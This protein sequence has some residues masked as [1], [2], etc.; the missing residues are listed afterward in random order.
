[1]QQRD[2]IQGLR[3]IAVL[4]VI[5]FHANKDWV[6]GGF[7][8]VDVFLVISGYLISS[9]VLRNKAD[10]DFRFG[11]FYLSRIRRIVPAYLVLL[12]VA[13]LCMAFLLTP[14]DYSSFAKSL[15]R[16]L[17]FRSN[18]FFS[19]RN[20]YFGPE[21]YE[22][23]LLHTWSLA[24][25]MQFYL[26]LPA[27]IIF[28]PKRFIG[29]VLGAVA[30]VLFTYASIRL[31][32]GE[33]QS[34][35]FSLAARIPEFLVGSL[36]ALYAFGKDW[37]DKKANVAAIV[38]MAMVLASFF[39]VSEENAFPGLLAVLPCAGVALM[40]AARSG[41]LN[42]LLAAKPLVVIGALSY[43]LYLW[44]WPILAAL[45]YFYDT[46]HLTPMMW[47]VFI[48][49]TL[50]S[51]YASYRFV[52]RPF[53]TAAPGR[54]RYVR[55]VALGAAM[56]GTIGVA[57][58]LNEKLVPPLP[59]QLT[60]YAEP[61]AICHSQIVGDC[62]RGD[63]AS[64]R[65]LL[66]IG[67]SHAGQLNLF[68]DAVGNAVHAKIRVIT[69]SSCVNIE[70]FDLERIAE[71]F[72]PSCLEQIN[73]AKEFLS[74]ADGL[75]LAGYWGLHYQSPK[76][77]DSLNR[78][79]SEARNKNKPVIVLAQTPMLD[80]NAQRLYRFNS[81]GVTRKASIDNE[82]VNANDVIEK[83]V[84]RYPNAKF[85]DMSRD[86]FFSEAPYSH[87]EL[88]YSD[89]THLNEIGSTRYGEA[90]APYFWDWVSRRVP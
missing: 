13:A 15:K 33:R 84:V 76:F 89:K 14:E 67:D 45:R 50:S 28:I 6:P 55:S 53:R 46:Y 31:A 87:G 44:H 62:L 26:L 54:D 11:K 18:H 82:W 66:L 72:R 78:F 12:A 37:T 58:A 64:D 1:M 68:A 73:H 71:G 29:P 69:A 90:V 16:A 25:E 74:S 40:I 75:I 2:D 51:S 38:G 61:E 70:G 79:L 9:I 8:G 35:Y 85:L 21:T 27:A 80:L 7:I 23:P 65:T 88:I 43:S 47:L 22:L 17:Y 5:A 48:A 30:T 4:A 10:G 3:A 39:L 34:M 63:K 59:V 49:L 83:I 41:S 60:R 19:G 32:N 56:L 86:A 36:I 20:D 52:E 57:H 42:R 81:L 77:L 24:V